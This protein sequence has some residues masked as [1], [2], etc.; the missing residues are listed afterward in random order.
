MGEVNRMVKK[1]QVPDEKLSRR[2]RQ[3]LDILF[4]VGEAS[5][6]EIRERLPD[7]PSNSAVRA[8]L[9]RLEA[10]GAIRHAAKELRYV[11]SPTMSRDRAQRSA[12]QRLVEVFFEGSVARTV[13]ALVE[14]S[15]GELDPAE[16]E[17]LAL[18]I[19]EGRRREEASND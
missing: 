19:R 10:K 9:A 18:L 8:T 12:V 15:E 2:E 4:E 13:T 11:Y 1:H 7:P 5:A 16:R 14:I 17:R 6:E 3:M